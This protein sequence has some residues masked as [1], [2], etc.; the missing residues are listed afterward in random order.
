MSEVFDRA[1]DRWIFMDVMF[2]CLGAW[3]GEEGPL[4]V[5][6]LHLFASQPHWLDRLRFQFFDVEAE[7]EKVLSPEECPERFLGYY[8]GWHTA[9]QINV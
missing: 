8:T 6:E 7:S 2:K 9:F 3:L 5:G 1:A 4:S